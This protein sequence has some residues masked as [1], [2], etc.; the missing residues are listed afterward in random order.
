MQNNK[1]LEIQYI[2]DLTGSGKSEHV[3]NM[4]CAS[5]EKY[6]LVAPKRALCDELYSRI[7]PNTND[8]CQNIHQNT[9]SDPVN[10]LKKIFKDKTDPTR[11][12]VTTHASFLSVLSK[13]LKLAD[14]NL[15]L[16]EEMPVFKEHEVNVTSYTKSIIDETLAFES[17]DN[18]F[19]R[20]VCKNPVFGM[21]LVTGNINDTFLSNKAYVE[22]VSDIMD[23]KYDTIVANDMVTE[24]HERELDESGGKFS[25]F[26]A[27]SLINLEVLKS[28][29]SIL[30]L[31]SF[32]EKT[33]TF[34]LLR[35][36]N[37]YLKP[38]PF[39]PMFK[40]HTNTDKITIH[41]FFNTNWSTT[42][43]R[44]RITPRKT[45]E[46]FVYEYIK[47]HIGNE[48]FLFN[49]NVGFRD[50]IK[51][52]TLAVSTHGINKYKEYTEL[53]FMPSLNA[54]SATV[55]VLSNFGMKRNEIDFARNVLTAYQFVSRGAVRDMQNEKPVNLYVMDKRTAMFLKSVFK[56]ASVQYHGLDSHLEETKKKKI[57]DNVKSFMSRIRKR[58]ERGEYVRANTL[59]KYKNRLEEYYNG[60]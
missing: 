39:V 51:G 21:N 38:Y 23:S 4:I 29:K 35:N 12:I 15:V 58:L 11:V 24:F 31:C 6:L 59:E 47:S 43:R 48:K 13:D 45:L 40:S 18:L 9:F 57:P 46:Q 22:M 42:L 30:T 49:A 53:V 54:T 44:K 52:G 25:K 60:G 41:Y 19:S 16:D 20:V 50:N 56:D 5:E 26:Y 37:C 55:K 33:I 7:F 17:K 34:K 14:W 3:V 32:F 1:P 36:L 2:S 8:V 27:M 28:F 10:R